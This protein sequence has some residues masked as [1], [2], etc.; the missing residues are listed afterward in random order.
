M[1]ANGPSQAF[2]STDCCSC[3]E[4]L[5]LKDS[6]GIACIWATIKSTLLG[7]EA[8]CACCTLQ[9]SVRQLLHLGT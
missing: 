4:M 7:K 1:R 2:T 3:S 9:P 5:L 8:R 6:Q